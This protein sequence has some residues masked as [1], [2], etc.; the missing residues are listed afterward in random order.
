MVTAFWFAAPLG[1]TAVAMIHFVFQ[2][3]YGVLRLHVA[4]RLVGSTWQES[5]AAM[6]PAAVATLG[7]ATTALPVSLLLPHGW[8]GLIATVGTGA[9]GASIALAAFSRTIFADLAAL[10]RQV[11]R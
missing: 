9:A 11:R 6:R 4:N 10:A 3:A 2:L 5:L 7:I 8:A 1:I